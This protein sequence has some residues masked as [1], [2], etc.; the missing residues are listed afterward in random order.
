MYKW[1]MNYHPDNYHPDYY[2]PGYDAV[3]DGGGS[4][5]QRQQRRY[6]ILE[7]E[8]QREEEELIL[9]MTAWLA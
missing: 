8:R 6:D 4:R 2:W 7:L 5:V 3:I 1:L 9:M